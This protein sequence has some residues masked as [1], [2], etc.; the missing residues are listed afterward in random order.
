MS[1]EDKKTGGAGDEDAGSA[2]KDKSKNPDEPEKK[3]DGAVSRKAY[4]QVADDMHRF[5]REA[6]DAR[7]KLVALEEQKLAE[8]KNWKELYERERKARAEAEDR[9][10]KKDGFYEHTQKFSE[11]SKVA[12]A[13]GLRQEAVDDLDAIDYGEAIK[14]EVTSNGRYIVHGADEFVETLKNKKPHWFKNTK[15][16]HVNSGGG[17]AAPKSDGELTAADVVAAERQWKSGKLD[18]GEYLKVFDRYRDQKNKKK[19]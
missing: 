1:D 19:A 10:K 4:Q 14:V 7:Q 5:K 13:Q 17:G 12:L 8:E 6:E 3:A 15:A 11:V 9:E 18:K 16:P 2:P